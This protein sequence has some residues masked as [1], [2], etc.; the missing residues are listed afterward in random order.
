MATLKQIFTDLEGF[1]QR[2]FQLNSFYSGTFEELNTSDIEFPM[3]WSQVLPQGMS[4]GEGMRTFSVAVLI[5]D[6]Y[7]DQVKTASDTAQV[8]EELVTWL[9]DN[10]QLDYNVKQT[11]TPEFTVDSFGGSDRVAGWRVVLQF[12]GMAEGNSLAVPLADT[13][14]V[15]YTSKKELILNNFFDAP[16]KEISFTATADEAGDYSSSTLSNV[17]SLMYTINSLDSAL[18]FSLMDGDKVVITI[19]KTTAG[20]EAKVKLIGTYE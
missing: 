16:T 2:H 8:V 13:V 7:I 11:G 17:T 10:E 5:L 3:M 15:D 20:A 18:P 9:N 6:R 1:Q 14:Q 12:R 19:I 4:L